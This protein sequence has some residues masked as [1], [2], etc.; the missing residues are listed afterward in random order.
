MNAAQL[1]KALSAY[2]GDAGNVGLICSD[3]AKDMRKPDPKF[4]KK[5]VNYFLKKNVKIK[6]ISHDG[7]REY[8]WVLVKSR[9]KGDKELRGTLNQDPVLCTHLHDKDPVSLNRSD[10]IDVCD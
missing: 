10:I 9:G 2:K 6:F 8:M 7:G 4:A 5:P 1:T 3:C